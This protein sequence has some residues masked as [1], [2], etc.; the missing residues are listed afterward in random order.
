MLRLIALAAVAVLAVTAGADEGTGRR[1]RTPPYDFGKVVLANHA[2]KAKVAAV[3][4]DH[5]LHR[6]R[7][8]CRVCHVDVGFAMKAGG[9][10]IR[11]AD[12]AAGQ[13]CG[14]CHNAKSKAD[15]GSKIFGACRMPPASA[16]EPTCARC[17]TGEGARRDQEFAS[18]A[19]SL[20]KGRFGNGIDWEQAETKRLI[21]PADYVE[22]ISMRRAAMPV[23]KDFA[24]SPKLAGMPDII[25]SHAK[26]TVWSG[27]EG[28]HP[29]IFT[30]VKRGLT[31]YTMVEIFDGKYCGACHVTV[32]FPTLDCQRCHSKAVE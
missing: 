12:N 20:P 1:R 15:D 23:Q 6:A 9:T 28:C 13:Y 14:A 31:K 11:A 30:G 8:T 2:T 10:D 5:W 16:T 32:A 4:F 29:E 3:V 19:R 7:Y 27:C 22:G 26:H 21:K 18:F 25:F 24:L 17:H